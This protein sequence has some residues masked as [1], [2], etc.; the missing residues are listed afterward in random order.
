MVADLFRSRAALETEIWMLRQQINVLRRTAPKK[1]T[2]SSIDRLIFVCLYRLRPGVRE[3]L[4]IVKP[5][6]VVKWHRSGFRL[7]WR[8]KSKARGASQIEFAIGTPG[9]SRLTTRQK[10]N[11]PC[12]LGKVLGLGVYPSDTLKVIGSPQRG[13]FVRVPQ[14]LFGLMI[15]FL[16]PAIGLSGLLP[17]FVSPMN[18]LFFG[19]VFHFCLRSGNRDPARVS[20]GKRPCEPFCPYCLTHQ[21]QRLEVVP[22]RGSQCRVGLVFV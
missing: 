11:A 4:A 10:R 17:Q 8:W 9:A 15:E 20:R 3:A 21:S 16:V 5:E 12:S 22:V 1:Q 7:Y 14:L 2:F 19:G 6:T 18:D 13:G